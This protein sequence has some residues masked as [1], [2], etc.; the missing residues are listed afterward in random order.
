MLD[1]SIVWDVSKCFSRGILESGNQIFIGNTWY[2]HK[3][4]YLFLMHTDV[5]KFNLKLQI[6]N[7]TDF[8]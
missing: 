5:Q 1:G 3:L 2:E 4:S 6:F 8:R 7:A